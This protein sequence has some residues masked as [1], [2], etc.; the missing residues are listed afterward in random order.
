MEARKVVCRLYQF[1]FIF[2]LSL[3][4]IMCSDNN[5]NTDD[6]NNNNETHLKGKL[7]FVCPDE[8]DTEL[9]MVNADGTN[10]V[11][12]TNNEVYDE[13]PSWSP[14]GSKI[15]YKSFGYNAPSEIFIMDTT[16]SSIVQITHD[17][18]GSSYEEDWPT[19]SS[20]ALRIMFETYRD[21]WNEDNGTT[22]AN[23]NIYVANANGSGGDLRITSHLFYEG[24]PCWSADG[25]KIA[26][27]HNEVD[28][29]GE[30]LYAT[31]DNIFVMNAD[32]SGWKQLTT[33]GINNIRPKWSPDGT[34]IVYQS[35]E[36]ISVVDLQGN[37]T[38]LLNYGGN[39]SWSPDG[40]KIVFDGNNEIYI[41]DAD[42]KNVKKIPLPIGA[43]QIVW[44]E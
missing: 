10:L 9:Y 19:W 15:A 32:G 1:L 25:S 3:F 37:V 5:N 2:L 23:A 43:R 34:K 42:G 24:M 11:R 8:Y 20:D 21:A 17:P 4:L 16:G 39:P 44:H 14:D 18:E 35:D 33:D 13:Q 40:T 7:V 27:V 29:V 30:M 6:N 36:G 38:N 41:M 28:S 22:L 12:L 31:G 26:F